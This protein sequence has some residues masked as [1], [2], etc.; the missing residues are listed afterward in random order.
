MYL[1]L[2][3]CDESRTMVKIIKF[4]PFESYVVWTWKHDMRKKTCLIRWIKTMIVGWRCRCC[5]WGYQSWWWW[6]QNCRCCCCPWS[7]SHCSL[8]WKKNDDGLALKMRTMFV[9]LGFVLL[10]PFRLVMIILSRKNWLSR[11]KINNHFE[12]YYSWTIKMFICKKNN[13]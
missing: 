9:S 4:K 6:W 12:W 13:A 1:W 8:H 2:P 3:K 5:W 10:L 11:F 7:C